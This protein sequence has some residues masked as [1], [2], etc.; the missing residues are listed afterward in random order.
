MLYDNQLLVCLVYIIDCCWYVIQLLVTCIYNYIM[1]C[2]VLSLNFWSLSKDL[3]NISLSHRSETSLQNLLRI[4]QRP[5][6]LSLSLSLS[7]VYSRRRHPRVP[8]KH[9][10]VD[11]RQCDHALLNTL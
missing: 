5:L 2:S 8:A 11:L 3:P 1:D 9:H 10:H 4:S 6:S 7:L